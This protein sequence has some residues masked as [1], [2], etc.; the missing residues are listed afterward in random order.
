MRKV[1]IFASK[2]LKETI[3][4]RL[5]DMEI[6]QVTDVS[7]PEGEHAA[8]A[9]RQTW[10]A[11][12]E[13]GIDSH[14]HEISA[15][16]SKLTYVKNYLTRYKPVRKGLVEMFIGSR[17]EV[18]RARLQEIIRDFDVDA[19]FEKCRKA[20]ER[21]KEIALEVSQIR[22]RLDA[23]LPWKA[24]DVPLESIGPTKYCEMTLAIFP[25]AVWEDSLEAFA[26]HGGLLA[27][28]SRDAAT[29]RAVAV[30]LR[31]EERAERR[32]LVSSLGGERVI[33]GGTGFVRDIIASLENE[34]AS[35]NEESKNLEKQSHDWADHLLEVM[36]LYDYHLDKLNIIREEAKVSKTRETVVIQ[37]WV[38]KRDVGRLREGFSDIQEIEIVDV[39]PEPGDN[40][41]VYL[42]NPPLI[43]PF[44]VITNIFGYPGYDEIDPTP[45]LAPFFWVFFGICLGD[46]VYGV[47]LSLVSWY[48]LKRYKLSDG[49][50]KLMRLLLYSGISTIIAGALMGSW[51]GDL[52]SV[53]FPGSAF[54]RF[55]LSIKVVDPIGEPLVLML[56]S[57]LM[58]IF[59]I[60]VGIIVKMCSLIRSGQVFEGIM[61]QGSWVLF[62]P[63]L[64][65]WAASRAG[66]VHGV[67]PQYWALAGAIMVM[68]NAARG[69]KNWLLK[70]FSGIYGLYGVVG[71]FSDT[72]S[73]ARLLALGL[74]SGVVAVVVNKLAQLVV[75]MIP[76]VGWG[77]V[78]IV[79]LAG[80]VFNLV[81]N[82]LGSF[83]HSGRLQF[84]EFF[85]KFF[86][87]GGKPFKPLTRHSQFV[88]IQ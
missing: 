6:M 33:L 5:R 21:Q 23:L 80:H 52:P 75:T 11:E 60:W 16:L 54:E 1:F 22:S 83:I 41:P 44:E 65:V 38:K 55:V 84:V 48:F 76:V 61:S 72:M 46:A 25:V 49:G 15:V 53:F 3:L 30:F 63:G 87:G 37:G 7:L 86:E 51:L 27:E 88:S 42:E 36:A 35:L 68:V 39:A 85:T 26:E 8:E 59:Q 19:W 2:D 45:I 32:D 58:G 82:A 31:D 34:I 20:D 13:G 71:Y 40:V 4:E 17:P 57:F 47:V 14:E 10:A 56:V 69:Q 64:L 9:T 12:S 43:R 50:Q 81:I 18:S 74:S 70:P 78:P 28:V 77:I 79:L 73:Y 29:V 67:W 62:L 66:L 24:L